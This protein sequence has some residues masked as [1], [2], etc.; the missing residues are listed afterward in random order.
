MKNCVLYGHGSSD[1]HGCEALVRTTTDFLYD[2]GAESVTLVSGNPERDHFYISDY[3]GKILKYG[4]AF[5]GFS[6]GHIA[7]KMQKMLFGSMNGYNKKELKALFNVKNSICFS[8]GGDNYCYGDYDRYIDMHSLLTAN[9]KNKTVFWGCSVTPERIEEPLVLNDLKQFSLITARESFTYNAMKKAGLTNV[10]LCPDPAFMLTPEEVEL[11]D[12]FE[13][14]VVGINV[15][16]LTVDSEKNNASRQNVHR[17]IRHILDDT[18]MNIC[19][20]P[21]VTSAFNDDFDVLPEFYERYKD[22]G[23]ICLVSEDRSLNCRQLKYIISKC[24]YLV[25]ARTHASIA[26]YSTGVPTLVIGY[27]VKSKGIAT[28]IFGTYENYVCPV[29]NIKTEND[30]ANCFDFVMA[31]EESIKEKC[32][33]Y[34]EKV[35]TAYE[36]VKEEL[37]K[38]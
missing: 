26:A 28:D 25:T 24:R 6:V 21:H 33:L 11:P 27:S 30:L 31:N 20:I 37:K 29:Q 12:K 10:M 18:D 14:D 8:I 17:L 1:N 22:T 13:K 19:F 15:S 9:G 4:E 35:P 7:A 3:K 5:S 36:K 34:C 38:L 16:P 23:R 2:N 32:G